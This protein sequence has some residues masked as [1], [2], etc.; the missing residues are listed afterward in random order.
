[1][2]LLSAYRKAYNAICLTTMLMINKSE[3][4]MARYMPRA[5]HTDLRA[6]FVLDHN[7]SGEVPSLSIWLLNISWTMYKEVGAIAS[8]HYVMKRKRDRGSAS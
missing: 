7:T 8:I 2:A 5:K 3:I 4:A 6:H 1:M